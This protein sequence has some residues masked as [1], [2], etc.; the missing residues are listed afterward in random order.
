AD[1]EDDLFRDQH[2]R[3]VGRVLPGGR[4]AFDRAAISSDL[5]DEDEPKLCPDPGPDKLSAARG[6]KYEDYVKSFVNPGN[7]TPSGLGFQ[8]PNPE[9]FGKLVYYDDCEQATGTMIEAKGPE[10]AGL[11]TFEKGRKSV[12]TQFLEQSGRQ[13][14][15]RGWRHLRWYFEEPETA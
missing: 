2:R 3:V 15:A 5:V 12:A 1:L 4:I 13:V 6:R 10:Y 11:L 9:S 14:A 7:P 8:L